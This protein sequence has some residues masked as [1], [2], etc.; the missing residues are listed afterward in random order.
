M[1]AVAADPAVSGVQVPA[2]G[3][4]QLSHASPQALSQQTPGAPAMAPTQKPD[5]HSRQ[6]LD[7][8]SAA[9]HGEPVATCGTHFPVAAQ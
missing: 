9:S 7:L 8:Q 5:A 2:V 3:V 4:A 6:G 1:H